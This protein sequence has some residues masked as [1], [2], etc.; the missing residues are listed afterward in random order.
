M[1]DATGRTILAGYGEVVSHIPSTD[2]FILVM[3]TKRLDALLQ[4]DEVSWVQPAEP[5]WEPIN[6]VA[7]ARMDCDSLSGA[8][9]GFADGTGVDILI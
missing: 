1:P 5:R 8:I 4:E 2:L 3:D 7:R 9:Y 6:G